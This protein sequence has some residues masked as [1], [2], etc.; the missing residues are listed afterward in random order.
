MT[1][2]F[3]KSGRRRLAGTVLALWVLA[4]LGAPLA[5]MVSA[6]DGA[7]RIMVGRVDSSKFPDVKFNVTVID[8]QYIPVKGLA[9]GRWEL[10]ED[11]K[12][13]KVTS[14]SQVI[15]VDS[16]ITVV[17]GI[18]ANASTDGRPLKDIKDAAQD[19]IF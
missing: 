17:L 13:A 11:G 8:Q 7:Y 9:D 10:L 2:W 1:R 14:I 16:P 4:S 12:P 15:D 3:S 5:G 19:F 6:A 18:D